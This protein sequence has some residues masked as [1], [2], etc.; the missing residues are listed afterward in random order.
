MTTLIW[1]LYKAL[2]VEKKIPGKKTWKIYTR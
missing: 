1:R 2:N